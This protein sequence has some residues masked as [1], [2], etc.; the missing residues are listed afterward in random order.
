MG[1]I[2]ED[3]HM[4]K[5]QNHDVILAI[6]FLNEEYAKLS[7]DNETVKNFKKNFDLII[8]DDG[9]ICPVIHMLQ[10]IYSDQHRVAECQHDIDGSE[11]LF[12]LLK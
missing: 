6:G 11:Q 4:A 1:D 7:E 3:S 12:K 9:S 5:K 2:V 10:S 8:T